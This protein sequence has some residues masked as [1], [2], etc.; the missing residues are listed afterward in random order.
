MGPNAPGGFYGAFYDGGP[1]KAE[2]K[3]ESSLPGGETL[4]S[5]WYYLSSKCVSSEPAV[6]RWPHELIRGMNAL[7]IVK[8]C[9]PDLATKLLAV[10][11][12]I[13]KQ[14][15]SNN[16]GGGSPAPNPGGE[17]GGGG[18]NDENVPNHL[19]PK[20]QEL[21]RRIQQQQQ[22]RETQQ[23]QQQISKSFGEFS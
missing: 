8:L 2:G 19:P 6:F 17:A 9:F 7:Q 15:N 13:N 18:E 11:Q 23:Q 12:V 20:Q 10:S 3:P 5:Q 4:Y 22:Q 1:Q 16:S 21:F 14:N